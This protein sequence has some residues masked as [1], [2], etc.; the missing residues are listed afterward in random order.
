MCNDLDT[1]LIPI[2]VVDLWFCR[3]VADPLKNGRL[4]S[5]R[6]ADDKD[7]EATKH[8][9]EVFEVLCVFVGHF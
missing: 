4:A 8:L 6:T 3:R 2:T 5:I 1:Y 7:S 9:L